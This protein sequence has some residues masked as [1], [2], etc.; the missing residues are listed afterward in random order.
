MGWGRGGGTNLGPFSTFC[1]FPGA[2][3]FF[4]EKKGSRDLEKKFP[5]FFSTGWK[6]FFL[7]RNFFFFPC[8]QFFFVAAFAGG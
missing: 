1:F 3:F 2:F 5:H 7:N 6:I 8:P 4:L